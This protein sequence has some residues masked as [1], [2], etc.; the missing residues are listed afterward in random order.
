MANLPLFLFLLILLLL[1]CISIAVDIRLFQHRL[2][3]CLHLCAHVCHEMT[4][5]SVEDDSL[6]F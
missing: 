4:N 6:I 2:R 1:R 3:V 5:L